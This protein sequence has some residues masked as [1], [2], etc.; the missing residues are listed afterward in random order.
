M[1]AE[2]FA[3]VAGVIGLEIGSDQHVAVGPGA[4]GLPCDIA[5]TCVERDEPAAYAVFPAAVADQHFVLHHQRCH[6]DGFAFVDV[7]DFAPPDFH[8]RLRIDRYRVAVEC[9]VIDPAI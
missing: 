3:F 2:V 9:R 7:R 4:V 1:N 5:R 8:A 6:G